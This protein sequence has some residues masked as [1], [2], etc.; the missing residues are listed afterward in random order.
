MKIILVGLDYP[1]TSGGESITKLAFLRALQNL[2]IDIEYINI[3]YLLRDEINKK[4]SFLKKNGI[5]STDLSNKQ[6]FTNFF[7]RDEI[8]TKKI[9]DK[10]LQENIKFI[11]FYGIQ[12]CSLVYVNKLN[13]RKYIILGDP[14][15]AVHI[16]S[17]K[18][19]FLN[20]LKSFS[21]NLFIKFLIY[22]FKQSLVIVYY[23]FFIERRLIYFLG[24]FATANHHA[25][26]YNKYNKQIIYHPAPVLSA[27]KN[28]DLDNAISIRKKKHER[29]FLIIGH[30]L[31]GTSNSHGSL[32]FLER[33]KSLEIF[34]KDLDLKI[35]IVG[36][37]N[38]NYNYALKSEFLKK[39]IKI[40]GYKDLEDIHLEIYALINFIEDT[41][42]N[43]T[44]IPQCFAYGIPALSHI[45]AGYGIPELRK[46]ES[47]AILFD[48]EKSFI[49]GFRKL[50]KNSSFYDNL[51][52]KS[53]K[54]YKKYHSEK[55]LQEWI[56]SKINNI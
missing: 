2:R 36:S 12:I 53:Y 49:S 48:D 29:I 46:K 43:R 20:L 26:Y 30:N 56:T 47:G 16:S 13:C 3:K 8:L 35:Y 34:T 25:M 27:S 54:V 15:S 37:N 10:I 28:F 42:G 18:I 19:K 33:I 38:D 6:Y 7:F 4:K 11:F 31:G 40:L 21:V 32:K 39:R 14:Q 51:S 45:S 1:G 23:Y 5:K 41:L 55:Y 44:R 52:R 17:L 22:F 24:G 9:Q 50:I